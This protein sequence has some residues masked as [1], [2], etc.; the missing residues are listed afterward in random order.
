M[1]KSK[2]FAFLFTV[3]VI[4]LLVLSGPVQGFTLS[5]DVNKLRPVKGE[6]VTFTAELTIDSGERLPVEE[7]TLVLNGPEKVT[8]RFD[9]SGN[10]LSNCHDITI[11]KILDPGYGY[12]YG[13]NFGYGYGF[14]TGKLAYLI[15]IDTSDFLTGKYETELKAKIRG[16]TFSQAGRAITIKSPYSKGGDSFCAPEWTCDSWS[17][18]VDGQQFRTCYRN[19]NYCEIQEKPIETRMCLVDS[20]DEYGNLKIILDGQGSGNIPSENR[21]TFTLSSLGF[22]EAGQFIIIL[23]LLNCII[24]LM[25]IIVRVNEIQHSRRKKRLPPLKKLKK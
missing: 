25:N 1:T 22:N 17:P 12:G 14:T 13:Y 7:L 8:C 9:T 19:L 10:P 4:G 16:E 6:I 18:C 23:L 20:Y 15:R 11:T 21:T 3:L 24:T 2:I 5:L